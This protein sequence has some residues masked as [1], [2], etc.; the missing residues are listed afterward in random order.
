MNLTKTK[1][2][3]SKIGQVTVKSSG[4]KDQ[5]GIYS[6]KKAM[7]DVVLCQYCGNW[8]YGRCAKI[9]MVANRLAM[10]FKCRKCKE[11]HKNVED[12]NQKL[13]DDVETVTRYS[14][15]GVRINSGECEAAVTSGTR[16]R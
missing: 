3:M 7:V 12:Q 16:L 1:V 14:Y 6:R 5:C 11:H 9:K 8:I 4:K 15:L 10:D 13:H 2:V